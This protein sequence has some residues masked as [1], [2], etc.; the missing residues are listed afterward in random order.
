MAK[1][2][3]KETE[4]LPAVQAQA[5]A[6]TVVEDFGDDA[7]GGL[8]NIDVSERRIPF[9]NILDAKSPQ[10]KRVSE[11]GVAGAMAGMFINTATNG[12]MDGELGFWFIAAKRDHYWLEFT[13]RN[14]GGGLVAVINVTDTKAM[15]R[16]NALKEKQGK[17]VRLFTGTKRNPD[18]TPVDGTEIGETFSLSGYVLP[19]PSKDWIGKMPTLEMLAEA[20]PAIVGFKSTQIKKYQMLVERAANFKYDTAKGKQ[21]PPLWAHA[22]LVRSVGE[23]N[24]KGDYYGY[25]ITLAALNPDGSEMDK[26]QSLLLSNNPVYQAGKKLCADLESGAVK[27]DYES[28]NA[29]DVGGATDGE[30][31]PF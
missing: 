31:P 3:V 21:N 26:R 23:K 18:G 30:D 15:Q 19:V 6:V 29:A 4:Q 2:Q 17:F 10:C 13:P 1:D 28:A 25:R 9:I 8:Q 16:I 20:F 7:G 14:L 5:G 22:W 24:K 12:L 11:G 27:A